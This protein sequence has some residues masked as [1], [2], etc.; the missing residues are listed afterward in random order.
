MVKPHASIQLPYDSE[1]YHN[2]AC[3]RI[4]CSLSTM[5]ACCYERDSYLANCG[6]QLFFHVAPETATAT[7][8]PSNVASSVGRIVISCRDLEDADD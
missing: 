6:G 8:T 7:A 5:L 4:V 2:I 3:S 1:V